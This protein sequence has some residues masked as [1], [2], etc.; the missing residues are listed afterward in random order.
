VSALVSKISNKTF[1]DTLEDIGG[2]A[3]FDLRSYT[4]TKEYSFFKPMNDADWRELSRKYAEVDH[5]HVY[6][7]FVNPSSERFGSIARLHPTIFNMNSYGSSWASKPLDRQ[8]IAD[9]IFRDRRFSCELRWNGRSSKPGFWTGGDQVEFL[10]GYTG[11]TVWLY[12]KERKSRV[13]QKIALDKLG[14]EI[15][16]G[17][18]CTYILYQFDGAGAA[19]IYFGNVTK[20]EP[21]GS[22]WC[23]NVKLTT[24]D[25]CEDKKVKDNSL[26]TIL[27]DDLM[28]QLMMAKLSNA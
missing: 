22:I 23:K 7:R 10:P 6:V 12:D 1:D 14:R 25:R 9:S 19:G 13:K 5:E 21:D 27:T 17:D 24:R 20:I 8:K 11:E 18:F 26:V 2:K 28:R 4:F 16:I 3:M 15:N